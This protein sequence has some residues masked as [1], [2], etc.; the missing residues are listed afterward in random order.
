MCFGE[1]WY[2]FKDLLDNWSMLDLI[3]VSILVLGMGDDGELEVF[4][5][6]VVLVIVW[7][8]CYGIVLICIIDFQI[9]FLFFMGVI[10]GKWGMLI[11]MLCFFKYYYDVN[12]LL[13]QVMLELVQDYFDIYVNMGIYDLGDKMFV[14]LCE[15]NLGVCFNVVY[16][17]LLV[18]EII[19]CDVYN[20]IVNNNIEM[21]VIENLLGCIV[22]NFVIFY[23]SGILMLFFGENFGDENSLQ[24]GYLY[25]L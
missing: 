15:N 17:I 12:M 21:V 2:G 18:V 19:L 7:F 3:K 13:V 14:W 10:C 11:N 25:L 23:L 5:V 6:F 22:V 8:G 4:G 16:F 24:V 9:M 20:V 1:I